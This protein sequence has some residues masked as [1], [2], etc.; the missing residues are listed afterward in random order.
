MNKEKFKSVVGELSVL[1]LDYLVVKK[2]EKN[3]E[4][5]IVEKA[6]ELIDIAEE[7]NAPSRPAKS[8]LP[9]NCKCDEKAN[10]SLSQSVGVTVRKI[11]VDLSNDE[12][13]IR[14]MAQSIINKGG[15]VD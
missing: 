6:R 5:F 11:L 1:A 2:I 8:E 10:D 3:I 12:K 4:K 7:E 15:K 14:A 9:C 13:F